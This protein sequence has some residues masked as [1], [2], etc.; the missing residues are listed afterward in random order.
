M[1]VALEFVVFDA[2]G[3]EVDWVDPVINYMLVTQGVYSVYNGFHDYTVRIPEG[4]RHEV[5]IRA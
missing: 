3:K 4:G 1:M 5:R 2:N